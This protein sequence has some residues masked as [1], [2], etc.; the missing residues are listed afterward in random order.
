MSGPETLPLSG[1]SSCL[2]RAAAD[3]RC[4]S[5]E[6]LQI[7]I[8]RDQL[9]AAKHF[10]GTLRLPDHL[11]RQQFIGADGT[12]PLQAVAQVVGRVGW[13]PTG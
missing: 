8:G 5:S 3:Q 7:R 12:E 10:A 13:P 1:Q 2:V 9:L 6:V 11:Q 4:C